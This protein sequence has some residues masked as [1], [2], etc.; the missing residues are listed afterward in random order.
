MSI[1]RRNVL[2]IGLT[3]TLASSL[4]LSAFAGRRRV[5][6]V[7]YLSDIHLPANR[8]ISEKVKS[9]I[10]RANRYDFV[11]F[12]GDNLMAVD[13]K[14]EPEIQTQF[15]MWNET[16]VQ[17]LKKPYAAVL[18][19]HDVEMWNPDDQSVLNGKGRTIKLFGMKDRYWSS[20]LNG[21]NLIGLDTVHKGA[22]G[23]IGKVDDEQMNWLDKELTNKTKPTL[24]LGHI[25]ILSVTALANSGMKPEDGVLKI[26]TASH[27][28]NGR[29]VS[30][31]FRESGNVKIALGGH[32]HMI[33]RC[34]FGGTAYHCAGAVSGGWWNGKHE[35][36]APNFVEIEL[37]DDGSFV[38][39]NISI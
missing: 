3:G 20:E 4:P 21:W 17:N 7:A 38:S 33:D 18:G 36:F 32:T 13:F 15:E 25:P 6:K 8:E 11:L 2:S 23:F 12:G 1:S 16:V 39:K 24:I 14:K 35:G 27:L 29:E 22:T 30:A 19:N 34:D 5:A 37:F 10:Q 31:L 26:S 28:A 9:I